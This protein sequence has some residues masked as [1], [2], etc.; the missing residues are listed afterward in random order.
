MRISLHPARAPLGISLVAAAICTMSMGCSAKQPAERHYYDQHIQP[1][2]TNFC[3]GNTS[4]C[5]RI[6]P[7]TGGALGNLDL[8]SFESVHKRPDVLRT[9]GSYPLPL[10]LLKSVPEASIQ[11]AYQDRFLQSEIVHAGGKTLSRDSDGFFELDTWLRN[12]ANRD[13]VAPVAHGNQGSGSCNTALPPD[14]DL[15]VVDVA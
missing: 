2:L 10:L 14:R 4:P 11:I 7:A 1:I 12:G 13:G 5:H 8:S 6:D 15:T 9:Y 3:V